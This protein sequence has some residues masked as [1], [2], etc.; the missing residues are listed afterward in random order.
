MEP[1]FK[2]MGLLTFDVGLK[3]YFHVEKLIKK[4]V[5]TYKTCQA[6]DTLQQGTGRLIHYGSDKSSTE[7]SG[8][9][10]F[11]HSDITSLTSLCSPMY[12]DE[13]EKVVHGMTDE[14]GQG[15]EILRRDKTLNSCPIP[16][17][18][19]NHSK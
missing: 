18:S 13:N 17:K 12:M 4:L 14:P 1:L 19:A 11:W 8:T 10:I 6:K 3:L 9:S 2:K 15:L 16:T 5:P 7:N